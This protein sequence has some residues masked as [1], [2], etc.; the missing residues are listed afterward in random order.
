[1]ETETSRPYPGFAKKALLKQ[2][3]RPQVN[4]SVLVHSLWNVQSG[5]SVNPKSEHPERIRENLDI[6]NFTLGEDDMRV[7]FGL[8]R[9]SRFGPDPDNFDF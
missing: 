5:L 4:N 3:C 8:N 2:N 9:D 6:F 7:I 1:M